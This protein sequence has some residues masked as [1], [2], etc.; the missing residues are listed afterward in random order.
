MELPEEA[1]AADDECGKLVYW[2]YGCRP[3]ARAW[4]EHYSSVL[5]AAGFKRLTASPVAFHHDERDLMGVVHGDDFM[6]VGV[7]EELDY[8]LGVLRKEYELKDRGRLGSGENDLKEVDM[9]GRRICWY[10][11]GLTW[12]GDA[13]HRKAV[14]DYF[15]M[16]DNTKVLLKTGY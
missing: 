10:D 5:G 12:E 16:G 2:L 3:A 15:G 1:G 6:F 4:E 13:R 11:W 7:D 8:V 9:L 14:L